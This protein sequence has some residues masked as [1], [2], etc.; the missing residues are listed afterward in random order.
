M[1]PAD[2]TVST[3]IPFLAFFRVLP[4]LDLFGIRPRRYLMRHGRRLFAASIVRPHLTVEVYE[5]IELALLS[6]KIVARW[7]RRFAFQI[8]VHAL[9]PP[10][11]FRVTGIG[12]DGLN[13]QLDEPNRETC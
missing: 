6:L 9:V 5:G 2:G 13:A 8:L 4:L 1:A 10:I 12:I 7:A 3:D 11:L